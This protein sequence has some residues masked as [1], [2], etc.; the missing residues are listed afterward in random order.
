MAT[1]IVGSV[2]GLL[3]SY[4][5]EW[6]NE[7]IETMVIETSDPIIYSVNLEDYLQGKLGKGRVDAFA[8]IG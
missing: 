7:Q 3:K 2:M 8:A 1:P 4:N 6:T 5:P